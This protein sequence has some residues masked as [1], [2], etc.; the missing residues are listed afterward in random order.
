MIEPIEKMGRK[1]NRICGDLNDSSYC[2]SL[3]GYA[4]ESFGRLDIVINNAG[5]MRRGNITKATDDDFDLSFAINVEAPFRISRAAIPIMAQAGGG[6]IVNT[7]SCWGLYPGPEHLVYCT[8]KA[9]L[10]MMTK[11]LARDHAHLQRK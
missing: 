8:T 10:A 4:R 1:V 5:L 6:T 3:P 9:A 7:A 11:C 2:D